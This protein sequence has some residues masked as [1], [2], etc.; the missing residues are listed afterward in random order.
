[1]LDGVGCRRGPGL[2]V[3]DGVLAERPCDLV[4]PSGG[5]RRCRCHAEL[6]E[7][8]LLQVPEGGLQVLEVQGL[9]GRGDEPDGRRCSDEAK[10]ALGGAGWRE[11]YDVDG[12]R[13]GI[14]AATQVD[15]EG[16]T[17]LVLGKVGV[18][19]GDDRG[20]GGVRGEVGHAGGRGRKPPSGGGDLV[21]RVQHGVA[22]KLLVEDVP[23]EG[24]VGAAEVGD[25]KVSPFDHVDVSFRRHVLDGEAE[26]GGGLSP[27]VVVEL[28]AEVGANDRGRVA[29]LFHGLVEGLQFV[30]RPRLTLQEGA[31]DGRRVPE[32][33]V[34]DVLGIA[35]RRWVEGSLEVDLHRVPFGGGVPRGLGM[36]GGRSKA[37]EVAAVPV[38]GG[39]DSR[40]AVHRVDG[41][42]PLRR[43]VGEELVRPLRG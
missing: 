33:E 27:P 6:V 26:V 12:S 17:K 1:M 23:G 41:V 21:V 4:S 29:P 13:S 34:H 37:T 9:P 7:V 28:A 16:R 3:G 25:A 10:V 35:D 31:G 43:R 20:V 38:V 22:P 39:L 19:V 42:D 40:E 11:G 8:G 30:V 5:G 18:A 32:G 2:G 36:G 15:A 14:P 24:V